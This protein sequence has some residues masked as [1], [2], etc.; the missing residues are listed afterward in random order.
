MAIAKPGMDIMRMEEWLATRPKVIQDMAKLCP[1]DR[2]YR[3]SS[4]HRCTIYSYSEDRTVT[5]EVTGEFN[6]VVF[7]RRVFGIPVDELVEC[8]LPEPGEDLGDT[9]QEAGY[10]EKDVREILIPKIRESMR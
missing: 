3:M 1:P 10:D 4:G 2:L 6:R 9:A 5:V 7:G 8:D